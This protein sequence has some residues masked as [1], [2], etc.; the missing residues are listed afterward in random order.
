MLLKKDMDSL[1]V[2]GVNDISKEHL[3]A[4]FDSYSMRFFDVGGS[5]TRHEVGVYQCDYEFVKEHYESKTA[6]NNLKFHFFI[7]DENSSLLRNA[8][9]DIKESLTLEK[10]GTLT[11]RQTKTSKVKITIEETVKLTRKS[12]AKKSSYAH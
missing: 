10:T 9:E 5:P 2:S 11:R 12:R 6:N 7:L 4:K 3:S 1:Y 8:E